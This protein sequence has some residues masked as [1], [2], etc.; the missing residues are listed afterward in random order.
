MDAQYVE[1]GVCGLSC[2][3][4]PAYIR[5][6][7]SRCPGCKTEFRFGGPCK[8]LHC[9]QLKEQGIEFC[10][11]CGVSD[12]CEIWAK[13]R[14]MGKQY[15]S[16]KCYQTL[17]KDIAFAQE[18]RVREFEKTQKAR[19]KLLRTMI[20]E[21]NEGRSKSYFCIA[22]TVM[23]IDEL[24][25]AI[26][27]ARTDVKDVKDVEDVKEKAKIMHMILDEIAEEKGYLLK[28]RKR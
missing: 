26:K 6:T 14:E 13:H 17:E 11:D 7:K 12:S 22:A 3:L 21:F 10:W 25:Q 24:E 4:C 19:E 2:R 18:H 1:I 20:D 23:N 8:M 9:K 16:P 27:K 15:D 28:L 5:T